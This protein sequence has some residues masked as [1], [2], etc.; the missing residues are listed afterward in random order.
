MVTGQR[1]GARD[2]EGETNI[3]KELNSRSVIPLVKQR[4]EGSLNFARE[5]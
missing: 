1:S 3:A 2:G 5:I 4:T